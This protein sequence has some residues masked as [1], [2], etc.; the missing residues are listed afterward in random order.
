VDELASAL[1]RVLADPAL[2]DTLRRRALQKV[3]ERFDV[4]VLTRDM[5]EL[6]LSAAQRKAGLGEASGSR[7]QAS[8]PGS[9]SD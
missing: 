7:L 5:Q 1:R 6:L 9:A 3:R 4:A 2:R 8:G